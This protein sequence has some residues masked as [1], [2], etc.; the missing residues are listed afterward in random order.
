METMV[1]KLEERV[2]KGFQKM[3]VD[4][5]KI[6]EDVKRVGNEGSKVQEAVTNGPTT[7]N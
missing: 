1:D 7:T 5:D 2:K 3:K 6:K 4:Q